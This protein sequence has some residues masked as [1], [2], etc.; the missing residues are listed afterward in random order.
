M[1]R[2]RDAACLEPAHVDLNEL[3]SLQRLEG[4]IDVRSKQGLL[5]GESG[6]CLVETLPANSEQIIQGREELQPIR[7]N[8]IDAPRGLHHRADCAKSAAQFGAQRVVRL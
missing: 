1:N 2:I 6:L 8:Q 3:V 7:L 5:A 4:C